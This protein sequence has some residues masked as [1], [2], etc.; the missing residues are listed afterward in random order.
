MKFGAI[1]IGTNAARLLVGEVENSTTFIKIRKADNAGTI[2]TATD[3]DNDQ[4]LYISC[5]YMV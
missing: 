5:T 3:T 1:D 2:V 4:D